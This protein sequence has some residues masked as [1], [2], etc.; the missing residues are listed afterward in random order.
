MPLIL[1]LWTPLP[2]TIREEPEMQAAVRELTTPGGS[3]S[4]R[5]F[6]FGADVVQT[7]ESYGFKTTLIAERLLGPDLE[8]WMFAA[9]LAPLTKSIELMVAVHPGIVTPQMVAKMGASLDRI[10]GGRFAINIV[11]GWWQQEF[12]LFSNGNW[13]TDEQ[14]RYKRMDEFAQVLDGL[15][16]KERFSLAGDFYKFDDGCVPTKSMR[17]PRPPIYAGSRSEIGKETVARYCDWWFV[18]HNAKLPA[19]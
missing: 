8:A 2:H 16:T 9:A 17:Q 5:S 13:S 10:S 11:N 19:V 7:A 3:G 4:D 6:S 15:W 14:T 1:G 18:Y 12:N